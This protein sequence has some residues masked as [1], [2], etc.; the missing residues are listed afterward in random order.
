MFANHRKCSLC[1][2]RTNI[3]FPY[4]KCIIIIIIIIITVL[5]KVVIVVLGGGG[6]GKCLDFGALFYFFL[7][8]ILFESFREFSETLIRFL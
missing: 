3:A 5:I 1:S 8:L 4:T 7:S 2:V 6:G